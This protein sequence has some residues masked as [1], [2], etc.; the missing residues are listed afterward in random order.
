MDEAAAFGDVLVWTMRDRNPANVFPAAD[1]TAHLRGKVIIDLNNR[2][3]ANEVMSDKARWFDTSLG[4]ELQANI[5]DVHVVKAFNTVAMEALDTS[6]KSLQATNT[7][8]FLAGQDDAARATVD[9]LATGLGFECVDLG[10][11]AVTM[12][13]AEA[14]GDI[15]RP[16]MI[17]QGKGGR[18]NIGI[19]MMDAPDL[20]LI[21]GREESKYH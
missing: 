15:V 11:G 10:G 14:L 12:R 20:N 3:Y 21:G 16:V 9:K 1:A 17:R 4:E 8:I 2:D 6:A 19:R 13:A 18:A 5:P 7:Q